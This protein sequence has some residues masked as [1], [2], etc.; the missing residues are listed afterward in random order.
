MSKT[1]FL[2]LFSVQICALGCSVQDMAQTWQ[3]DRLRVL[4]TQSEPAEAQPGDTVAFQ[5]LVYQPPGASLEGVVW[6]GCLGDNAT[7]FGCTIDPEL[8]DGLDEPPS[9]PSE[10]IAWFTELQEAGLLGFEPSLPP[11]WTIPEDA[12]EN[13]N[14]ED[15]VEGISA[16]LNLTAIPTESE[17]AE[18]VEVAF[19]RYPI[20]L[21]PEPNQNPMLSHFLIN[22]TEYNIDETPRVSVGGTL[23]LDVAF[24]DGAIQE[25]TYT[26]PNT[27]ESESRTE[28]PYL[29]WYT[30]TGTFDNFVSL[31][32]YTSVE[33]TA[34]DT[35]TR[36]HIIVTVRDRRGG[37]DWIQFDITV[38]GE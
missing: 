26:N 34:P 32:P 24:E 15:K 28:S 38:E 3:L 31:I 16:F 35:P 7:S 11:S 25:Y 30:E 5:S 9:D 1:W 17:D 33:W 20:S 21:N 13:L 4:A 22:G 12:L 10:Q 14:D 37:M 19:K 27:G 8:L 2:R 29:S 6:F 36:S 23:K 18:T